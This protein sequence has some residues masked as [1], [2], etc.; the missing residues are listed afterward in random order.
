METRRESKI[1]ELDELVKE[2]QIQSYIY[3]EMDNGDYESLR[4][5][6]QSGDIISIGSRGVDRS[7]LSVDVY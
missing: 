5:T 1:E 7:H 6:L 4:I 3:E 2:G